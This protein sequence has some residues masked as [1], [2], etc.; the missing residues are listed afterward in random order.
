[1]KSEVEAAEA[2]AQDDALLDRIRALERSLAATRDALQHDRC[3]SNL[4]PLPQPELR[5]TVRAVYF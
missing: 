1:M 4:P 3:V 2:E 5:S